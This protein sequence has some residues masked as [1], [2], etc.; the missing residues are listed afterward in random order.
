M[1]IYQC[2][3][4][5]GLLTETAKAQIADEITTIHTDA[6]GAP[7]LFVS[8]V[9]QEVQDGDCFVAREPSTH[10]YILGMIRHGRSLETR[11]VMLREFSHMWRR[12]TGQSEAELLV[13]LTEVD[14][15]SAMESGLILPEPGDEQEWFDENHARLAE[16]GVTLTP[17]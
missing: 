14:P 2:Y 15:A 10:S 8:V 3:S 13:A 5:P 1:P 6:T 9:F 4:P 16:L 7:E 17:W 12:I 11:Q